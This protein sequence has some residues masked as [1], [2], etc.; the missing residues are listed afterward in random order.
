MTGSEFLRKVNKLGASENV[1]VRFVASHG[2][3][4]HGTLYYGSRFT[5]LKARNK[6]LGS[7]LVRAMCKQ[8]GIDRNQL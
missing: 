8:L 2:K 3:G 1:A 5:T 4:S 7:G 6:E